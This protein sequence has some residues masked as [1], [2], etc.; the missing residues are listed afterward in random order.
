MFLLSSH[1]PMHAHLNPAATPNSINYPY[2]NSEF[3]SLSYIK[4]NKISDFKSAPSNSEKESR[5]ADLT[6]AEDEVEDNEIIATK[7]YS[8]VNNYFTTVFFSNK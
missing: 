2:S 6:K 3:V 5:R 8:V 1:N 4:N 7:K